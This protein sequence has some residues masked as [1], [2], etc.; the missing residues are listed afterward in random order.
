MNKLL[1]RSDTSAPHCHMRAANVT[2]V[3]WLN[4]GALGSLWIDQGSRRE[5]I[6]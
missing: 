6:N 1:R 2:V 3:D 4:R 5:C